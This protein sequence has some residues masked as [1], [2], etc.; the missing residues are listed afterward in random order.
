MSA[1]EF[2]PIERHAA[3]WVQKPMPERSFI[4]LLRERIDSDPEIT[5]SGLAV[6]AGMDN[7]AIRQM[8]KRSKTVKLETAERI[9]AALGTTYEAFMSA[10]R[11]EDEERL[12][13]LGRQLS[14]DAL[15]ELLGYGEALIARETQPED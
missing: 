7:S 11:S 2:V 5:A 1:S 8:L 12:L 6:K 15:R 3:Q 14:P 4:E 13:R 9:C 10:G